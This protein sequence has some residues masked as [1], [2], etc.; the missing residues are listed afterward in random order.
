VKSTIAPYAPPTAEDAGD[1]APAAVSG[2]PDNRS[3]V[4]ITV[5]IAEDEFDRDID[6]AFRK[7]A[8]EVRLPGF[9]AGKAPRRVLEAR[10]GTAAAREQALRDAIPVYLAK[11]VREHDVDLVAT[12][13]II[14]TSGED[15]GPVGFDA[16]LEVRPEVDVAGYGAI[17]VELPTLEPDYDEVQQAIDAELARHGTLTTVERAVQSG[18]HVTL[19]IVATRDGEPVPGLNTEGWLYEVGKGWVATGFDNELLGAR[20]GDELHF[21]LAPSG[22]DQD[23]DF[24]VTVGAVQTLVLPELSDEWVNEHVAEHD[25]V[26]AWRNAVRDR[27]AEARLE[28]ARNSFV[29]TTT[30]ALAE[31][32]EIEAPPSMVQGELERRVRAM[33]QQFEARGIPLEQ[34]LA[35]TGQSTESFLE[36][37]RAQSEQAVKVDLALRAIATAEAIEVTDDDLDKEYAHMAMHA[38]QKASAVRRAYEQNDAVSDLMAALRKQKAL[39]WLL[40]HVEV[41]DTAGNPIDRELVTRQTDHDDHDHDH[42]HDDVH[43]HDH[44]HDHDEAH[45]DHDHDDHDDE[46]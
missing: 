33:V 30:A 19:D 8:R 26:A 34:W 16:T 3:L 29:D 25:D 21:T 12:P 43:D 39:D 11:A 9:R 35:A 40:E 32:V 41:V 13:E 28:S 20:A 24:E 31:L 36:A 7:I 15:G 38:G 44:D 45:D 22:T 5:E 42:D 46:D 6:A 10:I 14:I 37:M 18:D 27:L 23:A 17:R 2:V 1:D 4:T